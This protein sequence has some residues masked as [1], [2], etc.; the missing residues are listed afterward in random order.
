[1][2]R[3]GGVS[4]TT[5]DF[6]NDTQT[7]TV[8]SILLGKILDRFQLNGGEADEPDLENIGEEMM[9]I[10]KFA[11]IPRTIV[12]SPKASYTSS[13]PG[14]HSTRSY[15]TSSMAQI[16]DVAAVVVGCKCAVILRPAGKP[17][18]YEGMDGEAFDASKSQQNHPCLNALLSGQLLSTLHAMTDFDTPRSLT[19]CRI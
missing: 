15:Y 11:S 12:Q 10:L 19:P 1:M 7:L 16:N 13:G 9:N 2:W 17:N 4:H 6:V 5:A 18:H 14:R 3:A 8:G